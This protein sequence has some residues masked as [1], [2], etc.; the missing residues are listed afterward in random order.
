MPKADVDRLL[1]PATMVRKTPRGEAS[2]FRGPTKPRLTLAEDR[3]VEMS[4]LPA[5]GALEL[6]GFDLFSG[7]GPDT[8]RRIEQAYGPLAQHVGYVVSLG[9]GLAITGFHDGNDAQRA[10]TVFPSGRWDR[11]A[12]DLRPITFL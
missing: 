2:E 10:I 7:P 3:L 5:S 8:L 12:K 4:F 6:D 9:A 11:F 1:G